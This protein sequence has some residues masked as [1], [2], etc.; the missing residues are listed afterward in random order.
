M[1]TLDENRQVWNKKYDWLYQGEEWSESWGGSE[2]Q[3]F[4]SIFPRIHAFLPTGSILELASGYG[5]WT[6]YLKDY[7]DTLSGIDIAEACISACKERFEGRPGLSFF[8]NDGTS[9]PMVQ[10]HSIDF[11]FSFDSLVHA[12]PEVLRSYLNEAR[13]ILKPDGIGF[14]HHSNLGQYKNEFDTIRQIPQ[15]MRDALLKPMF[16]GKTHWRSP[17]MSSELFRSF[18]AETGLVCLRQEVVNW[19]TEN[20]LIDCFSIFTQKGS[21][22]VSPFLYHENQAFMREANLIRIL[23]ALY[24]VRNFSAPD[25]ENKPA[26]TV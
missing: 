12:E 22:Y 21:E 17:N 23:S 9:L 11:I 1:A 3:W 2:A 6:N 20:L 10:D 26:G 4:G 7:C 24:C 14:F 25:Q 15:E 16:T 5:R 19:G 8:V 18:C 13:R